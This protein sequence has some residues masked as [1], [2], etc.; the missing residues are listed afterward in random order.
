MVVGQREFERPLG[1]DGKEPERI[2]DAVRGKRLVQLA[3][4]LGAKDRARIGAARQYGWHRERLATA[5]VEP[6]ARG[7]QRQVRQAPRLQFLPDRRF[8]T[9]G[10]E[11]HRN[12]DRVHR[13]VGMQFA[14]AQHRRLEQVQPAAHQ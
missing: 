6:A 7:I 8:E 2:D 10:I 14:P 4:E 5:I 3:R 12:V 11:R 1:V 9:P 13:A